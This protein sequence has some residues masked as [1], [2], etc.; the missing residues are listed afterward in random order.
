[1]ALKN[2]KNHNS[3]AVDLPPAGIVASGF[4]GSGK[5]SILQGIMWV[6]GMT[7]PAEQIL[8]SSTLAPA[9]V[10]MVLSVDGEDIKLSRTLIPQKNEAGKV[11]ASTSNY[12]INDQPEKATLYTSKVAEIFGTRDWQYLLNPALVPFL[13]DARNILLSVAGCPTEKEFLQGHNQQLA[14]II[15]NTSF[16]EF[17]KREKATIQALGKGID[18]IPAKI[19]ELSAMLQE[20]PEV[21]DEAPIHARI[22]EI[23]E[24]LRGV[25]TKNAERADQY[26]KVACEA[27]N[28]RSEAQKLRN[29]AAEKVAQT[30]KEVN[31]QVED[32][33]KIC[34][35]WRKTLNG[36][37]REQDEI[38]AEIYE[39]RQDQARKEKQLAEINADIQVIANQCQEIS[40][41][42]PS[43]DG[44]CSVCGM[45]CAKLQ[46]KGIEAAIAAN[47][48]EL[49][50]TKQKGRAT[51]A[52]RDKLQAD[53]A[54]IAKKI[55]SLMS[56]EHSNEAKITALS[57]EPT[58]PERTVITETP[59][60][61][62]LI[63]QAQDLEKTAEK[64]IKENCLDIA[65]K[66]P[67]L[68]DEMVKLNDILTKQGAATA[69]RKNNDKITARIE[70]LRSEESALITTQ[71]QHKQHLAM[72]A[73]FHKEYANEVT[74]KCNDIFKDTEYSVILFSENMGNEKG[75]PTFLASK[76]GSTNLSHSEN[77]MF[78][79]LFVERVLGPHF[80]L[81]C[82]PM[83]LDDVE[84]IDTTEKLRSNHQVIAARVERHE[85]TITNIE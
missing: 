12:A 28:L 67:Q 23:H 46:A 78:W 51:V 1:M 59:E 27:Q 35:E 60:S 61:L 49:D 71:L 83:I 79:K 48:Q 22:A 25:D 50:R 65:Q 55:D 58:R 33:E 30:N 20:I 40:A 43:A 7:I 32:A 63:G 16:D 70:E 42:V 4:N 66:D 14:N 77:T 34:F 69:T 19:E 72:L 44:N 85:L 26:N 18:A 52:Q 39:V 36:F 81:A 24:I 21:V 13:K 74:G 29:L 9:S 75:N 76:N 84:H 64:L 45:Y 10:E 3:L 53:I 5:S 17:E 82:C 15:G 47:A 68:V 54:A 41:R 11:V 37:L 6:L 73:Q 38:K 57:P 56:Q 31:K 80:G 62:H 8:N 2:F